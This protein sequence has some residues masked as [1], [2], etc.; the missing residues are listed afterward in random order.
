MAEKNCMVCGATNNENNMHCCECGALLSDEEVTVKVKKTSVHRSLPKN[1]VSFIIKNAML[2]V[3]SILLLVFA[4]LPV[5][6]VELDI[7]EF[8]G[9]SDIDGEIEFKISTVD[10]IT[11]WFDS[12]QELDNEERMDSE[13]YEEIRELQED[14][15]DDFKDRYEGEDVEKIKLTRKQ[16]KLATSLMKGY[17]RFSLQSEDVKTA[18]YMTLGMIFSFIYLALSVVFFALCTTSFIRLL[19]GYKSWFAA[20][21]KI[22]LWI[23]LSAVLLCF[24]VIPYTVDLNNSS[25]GHMG[26]T[27]IVSAI[28]CFAFVIY[29]LIDKAVRTKSVN[30]AGIVKNAISLVCAV[31]VL[32][33]IFAP[34]LTTKITTVFDGGNSEKTADISLN[35]DCFAYLDKDE[36]AD[37]FA[38][39]SDRSE[40]H[41]A[42]L[43]FSEYTRREVSQGIADVYNYTYLARMLSS[44]F[45]FDLLSLF[46][47]TFYAFVALGLCA[48]AVAIQN[49]VYLCTGI[50]SRWIT[51]LFKILCVVCA[52]AILVVSIIF[53]LSVGFAADEFE[54]TDNYT[55]KV[56][57]APIILLI[58][59]VIVVCVP[60]NDRKVKYVVEKDETDI[61]QDT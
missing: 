33:M 8:Y 2:F 50:K 14:L 56:A 46:A 41:S 1:N 6:S 37:I 29:L 39:Y 60:S 25:Y 9:S 47:L 53:C 34:V 59:A 43:K 57:A 17:L 49:A 36:D 28:I 58:F 21:L 32:F 51:I 12:L 3:L 40:V 22:T 20:C 38:G 16:E 48:G 61:T 10:A 19:L 4:F 23:P 54:L 52:F 30:I 55:V 18:G 5:Y 44:V 31:I 15:V 42:F 26:T 35:A 7:G 13:L 45:D 11:F 24:C 27:V